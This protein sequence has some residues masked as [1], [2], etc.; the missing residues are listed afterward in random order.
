VLYIFIIVKSGEYI[1]I[2][3]VKS[4]EVYLYDF[5]IRKY[6]IFITVYIRNRIWFGVT[7]Y[8]SLAEKYTIL[9]TDHLNDFHFKVWTHFEKKIRALS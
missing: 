7:N 1:F 8:N 2:I 3:I 4:S 9:P 5:I 6:Q